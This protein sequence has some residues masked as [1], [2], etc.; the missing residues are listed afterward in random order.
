MLWQF[1]VSRH[2]RAECAV[3]WSVPAY[4]ILVHKYRNSISVFPSCRFLARSL[5]PSF[6]RRLVWQPLPFLI[7][8]KNDAP[9]KIAVF[10]MNEQENF[11]HASAHQLA[12]VHKVGWGKRGTAMLRC[13]LTHRPKGHSWLSITKYFPKYKQSQTEC[14]IA[15]NSSK[16]N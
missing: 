12:V 2:H 8:E 3:A 14:G 5:S 4:A 15:T 9:T 1:A 16:V 6:M 10:F 13:C 7:E 11:T